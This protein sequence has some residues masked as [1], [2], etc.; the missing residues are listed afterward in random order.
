MLEIKNYDAEKGTATIRGLGVAFG[1]RD[2]EGDQFTKDTDLDIERAVGRGVYYH[3]SLLPEV[4]HEIGRISDIEVKADGAWIEA[5]LDLHKEYVEEV[6]SL[7]EKGSLGYSTGTASHL[8]IRDEQKN[9]KRWHIM[10]LSVTPTPAEHR[11]IGTDKKNGS[12]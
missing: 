7:I 10:E 11:T 9:L 2:L 6:L 3:H 4:T 8:V 1:G 5:Q 12:G